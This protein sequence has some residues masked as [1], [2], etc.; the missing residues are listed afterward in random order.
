VATDASA[1]DGFRREGGTFVCDFQGDEG[2]DEY[3]PDEPFES[4]P[5]SDDFVDRWFPQRQAAAQPTAQ[6][7]AS[8]PALTPQQTAMLVGAIQQRLAE[9]SAQRAA[10]QAREHEQQ[11]AAADRERVRSLKAAER[12]TGRRRPRRSA[13]TT[14]QD[15]LRAAAEQ[16]W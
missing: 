3:E 8:P 6:P 1:I 2:S 7:A 11:L 12:R 9:Q 4:E 15:V 10:E 14:M 16:Q 5:E 13:P